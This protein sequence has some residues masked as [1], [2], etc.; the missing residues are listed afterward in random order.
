MGEL[1]Y[2]L[3]VK[4]IQDLADGT[5]WTGQPSYTESIL[6]HCGMIDSKAVKTPQDTSKSWYEAK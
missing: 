3:G 5:V 4:M 2:F 1:Q 6:K